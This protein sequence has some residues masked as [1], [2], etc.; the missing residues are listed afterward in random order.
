MIKPMK[1]NIGLWIL[2]EPSTE[3]L[4]NRLKFCWLKVM[5]CICQSNELECEIKQKTGGAKQGASQKSWRSHVLPR[6]PLRTATVALSLLCDVRY[7]TMERLSWEFLIYCYITSRHR[8]T[9]MP[10][11]MAA[12]GNFS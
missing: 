3:S 6:P 2:S 7:S 9:I 12:N 4:T 8:A 1:P 5:C 10:A 11:R